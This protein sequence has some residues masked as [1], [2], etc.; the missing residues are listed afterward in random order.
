MKKII[1][2]ILSL[3][4][5][6]SIVYAQTRRALLIGIDKYNPDNVEGARW[7]NLDGCVNDIMSIN[8]VLQA[9]FGFLKDNITIIE[10]DQAGRD[11]IISGLNKLLNDSK[12]GDIAVLYYSGHGSQVKNSLSAEDDKKDESM[13]PADIRKGAKDI[14]DK[15]LAAI[16]DKFIDKGVIITGIFD[17]CHSGSIARGELTNNPPKLRYVPE[18]DVD[19]KD[20][21][22][23]I[24]PENKGMLVMS[25][26]QDF[27]FASEQV[28]QNGA[29]HG[30]FTIALLQTLTS[31]PSSSS[32]TN[33]F[34]S[35]R[36]ILKYNGKPQE[37]VL[38]G[39]NERKKQTL[40]GIDKNTL[41]NKTMIAVINK[42]DSLVKLQGGLAVG[43][44][45]NS[46]LTKKEINGE[47]TKIKVK[48]VNGINT[49]LAKVVSGDMKNIKAG[50]LFELTSWVSATGSSL[51]VYI[52]KSDFDYNNLFTVTQN[53]YKLSNNKNYTV[54][55]DPFKEAPTHTIFF[56]L[57]KWF[58][59]MPDGKSIDLGANPDVNNISKLIPA[60]A[61]IMIC[62]PPTKD[63]YSKFSSRFDNSSSVELVKEASDAQYYLEGRMRNGK[64][65]YAFVEPMISSNDT[66]YESTMPIRTDYNAISN[67][68]NST[69][70]VIDS[71]EEYSYKLAKIKAWLTMSGPSDD[72]TFPFYLELKNAKTNKIITNGKVTKGD[73]LGLVLLTDKENEQ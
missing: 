45:I 52:P 34:T 66:A 55:L 47:T 16:F 3:T 53:L 60:G 24:P 67:D 44:N 18:V 63:F 48:S 13:V 40:F 14:R 68:V 61:K 73:T 37:P 62:I 51:K 33:I 25:A 19:V 36:A 9:K 29:P 20:P 50:D 64:I 69:T 6:N 11:G 41:S 28:D 42:D 15:E 21:T 30:A 65:E 26:S 22:Q 35:V 17:C 4:L 70:G 71:L 10:N 56:N 2:I 23:V 31:Q 57:N 8:E 27:E 38:A 1:I 32:A 49:C 59:G 43:L 54:I 46:E 72:G 5:F 7:R 12:K 39:T 58:L